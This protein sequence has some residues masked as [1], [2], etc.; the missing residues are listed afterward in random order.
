MADEKA[1]PEQ[2]TEKPAEAQPQV[3]TSEGTRPA[4]D[5]PEPKQETQQQPSKPAK[6]SGGRGIGLHRGGE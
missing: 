5:L 2:A 4:K 1:A 6:A 3:T